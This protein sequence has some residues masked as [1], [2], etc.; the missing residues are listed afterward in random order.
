MWML[1]KSTF[2]SIEKDGSLCMRFSD[3]PGELIDLV[4]RINKPVT[5]RKIMPTMRTPIS[6]ASNYKSY[7]PKSDPSICRY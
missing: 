3:R 2:G 1:G 6:D 4:R 7:H 5:R